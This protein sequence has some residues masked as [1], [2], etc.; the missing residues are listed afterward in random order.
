M[1]GACPHLLILSPVQGR[2]KGMGPM[3]DCHIQKRCLLPLFLP[4][5]EQPQSVLPSGLATCIF[6]GLQCMGVSSQKYRSPFLC[7]FHISQQEAESTKPCPT[8]LPLL[9]AGPADPLTWGLLIVDSVYPLLQPHTASLWA[10]LSYSPPS[11][12]KL[13]CCRA[14]SSWVPEKARGGEHI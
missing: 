14:S 13:F 7:A 9:A 8:S 2:Q 10:A 6:L 1:W 5:I 4:Y 3:L 11:E 12:P